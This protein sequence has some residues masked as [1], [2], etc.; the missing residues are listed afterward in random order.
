MSP[1]AIPAD[2]VRAV[3]KLLEDA[4]AQA[5]QESIDARNSTIA[6]DREGQALAFLLAAGMVRTL[7]R[8]VGE[9]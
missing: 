1:T 5:R 6:T 9:E 2:R 8:G 3:L 7:L 4:E